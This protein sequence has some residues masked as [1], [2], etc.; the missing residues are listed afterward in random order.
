MT[1]LRKMRRRKKFRYNINR[2][3]LRNKITSCGK[4]SCKEIADNW[5]RKKSFNTNL[6]EMGLAVDPNTCVQTVRHHKIVDPVDIEVS[7]ND[8]EWFVEETTEPVREENASKKMVV[9]KLWAEAKAPRVKG[10]R[11]P[12]SVVEWVTYLMDTY[13]SNYK[14]MTRDKKNTDQETWKQ[15]RRKIKLFKSIEVQYSEY[16]KSRG[17]ENPVESDVSSDDEI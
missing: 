16:L 10:L 11:L 17:I 5:D 7:T 6:N 8:N 12:G 3:R 9:D 4:I 14:A 2:K 1:K 15:L 13:G